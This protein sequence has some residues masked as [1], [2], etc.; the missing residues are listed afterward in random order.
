MDVRDTADNILDMYRRACEQ[1]IGN[2]TLRPMTGHVHV[3]LLPDI[4]QRGGLFLPKKPKEL[5]TRRIWCRY[6]TVINVGE[7]VPVLK[8]GDFVFFSNMLGIRF[9]GYGN[10]L[11][12]KDSRTPHSDDEIRI[13]RCTEKYS[14]VWGRYTA[15]RTGTT[16][17]Y[18]RSGEDE[19]R[20]ALV[21]DESPVY[22][23]YLKAQEGL[24]EVWIPYRWLVDATE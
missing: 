24:N 15:H 3:Q 10:P 19:V 22:G 9:R 11:R 2:D 21:I 13:L 7:G 17:S 18:R 4:N 6:G 5:G 23:G 1:N 8:N 16:V 14:E 12:L 20:Q